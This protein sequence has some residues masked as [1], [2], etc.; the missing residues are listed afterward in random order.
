MNEPRSPIQRRRTIAGREHM[1]REEKVY[2][3][4]MGQE[5]KVKPQ[6]EHWLISL[7]I[8]SEDLLDK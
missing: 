4:I 8:D 1:S 2:R 6:Y 5:G 7:E 3:E